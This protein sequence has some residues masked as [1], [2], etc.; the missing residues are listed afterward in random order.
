[1]ERGSLHPNDLERETARTTAGVRQLLQL[2]TEL[3][4]QRQAHD[5]RRGTGVDEDRQGV[6]IEVSVGLKVADTV[7]GELD[8][9]ES[10]VAQ[11]F[12]EIHRVPTLSRTSR[13]CACTRPASTAITIDCT[14]PISSSVMPFFLAT[15]RYES[16][17]G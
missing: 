16:I 12:L 11:E 5:R 13:N 10:R 8:F 9:P 3:P 4:R 1:M 7:L 15:P 14:A 6:A 2:E 17:H